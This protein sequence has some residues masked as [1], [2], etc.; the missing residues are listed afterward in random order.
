MLVDK[1]GASTFLLEVLWLKYEAKIGEK[2]ETYC[3]FVDA[4]FN[5]FLIPLASFVCAG[6]IFVDWGI[7][8]SS[9]LSRDFV[10]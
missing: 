5:S 7:G 1:S 3:I 4:F 8:D 10:S 2:R 6:R 9:F